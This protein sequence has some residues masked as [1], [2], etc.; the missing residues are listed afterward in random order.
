MYENSIER[1]YRRCSWDWF[2]GVDVVVVKNFAVLL[3]ADEDLWMVIP[4]RKESFEVIIGSCK[5]IL[6][7][8]LLKNSKVDPQAMLYFIDA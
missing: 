6:H 3:N 7:C 1:S 8:K 5:C 4:I 2:D